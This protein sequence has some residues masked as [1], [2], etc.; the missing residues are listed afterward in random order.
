MAR[1][2][3]TL[4]S[5]A[6]QRYWHQQWR[7]NPASRLP[8][9]PAAGNLVETARHGDLEVTI[10]PVVLSGLQRLAR[11][12]NVP[13]KS[14]LLSAHLKVVGVLSGQREVSTG[15]VCHGRLEA[16]DAE[17]LLGL[18][19]NI[20]PIHLQVADLPW[21]QLAQQTFRLERELLP[22]RR[23]PVAALARPGRR[24]PVFETV[25]NFVHF[26]VLQQRQ[27]LK[28]L[29][30][31]GGIFIDPFPYTLKANFILQPFSCQ[32][33]CML[34][35]NSQLLCKDLIQAIGHG[36]TSVLTAMAGD[37]MPG[38]TGTIVLPETTQGA[39][40]P[41]VPPCLCSHHPEA[42]SAAC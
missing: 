18:F 40:A 14:V 8:H 20:V 42:L 6:C 23:Y 31:L 13:L 25:F 1:E 39:P 26:R 3:E 10:P 41:A 27:G 32:L 37:Q 21:I 12:A 30:Y 22:F 16:P 5:L 15:V 36:Y 17:R 19:L 28:N 7:D 34:T 35:Y 24:Q 29:T 9:C 2:R 33:S 38:L 11:V 4:H